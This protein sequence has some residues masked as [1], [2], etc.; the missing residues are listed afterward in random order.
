MT[1]NPLKT[2]QAEYRKNVLAAGFRLVVVSEEEREDGVGVCV[3]NNYIRGGC[4]YSLE[5]AID[6]IGL[7]D[8]YVADRSAACREGAKIM[9]EFYARWR[10]DDPSY[11][12][13]DY[14][15]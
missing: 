7:Y 2:V 13:P 11:V 9:R 5:D 1:S 3:G 10:N 14:D 4:W 15:Q 8:N 12:S 6:A